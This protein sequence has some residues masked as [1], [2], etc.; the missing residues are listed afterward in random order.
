MVGDVI[1]TV[2]G[3]LLVVYMLVAARVH[4]MRRPVLVRVR[5]PVRAAWIPPEVYR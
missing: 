1:L 3:V 4:W 5:V 2:V